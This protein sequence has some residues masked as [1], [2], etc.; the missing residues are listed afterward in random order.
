MVAV[1][2][3]AFFQEAHFTTANDFNSVATEIRVDP[4]RKRHQE[5]DPDNRFDLLR[6]NSPCNVCL[7]TF[8][9]IRSRII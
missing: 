2:S 8:K 1:Q 5:L 3:Y 4:A 7:L 9:V 6:T